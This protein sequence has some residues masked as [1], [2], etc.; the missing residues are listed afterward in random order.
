MEAEAGGLKGCVVYS[1]DLFDAVTIRR[2]M[3]HFDTVLHAVTADDALTLAQLPLLRFAQRHQL[4]HGWNDNRVDLP[5]PRGLHQLFEAQA[6]RT[7]DAGAVVWDEGELSYRCLDRRA[8]HLA[9]WLRARGV[10]PDSRVAICLDPDPALVVGLLA[11]LKAGGGYVPLDP[12]YPSQ[13]LALMLEDSGAQILLTHKRLSPRLPARSLPRLFVDSDGDAAGE[14]RAAPVNGVKESQAA[15][16]LYTSGTTGRPRGVVI[17]HR[18][19]V[20][21]MLWMQATLPLSR[22]DRVLQKTPISFDASVWE[23]WAPLMVGAGLVLARPGGYRDPAYLCRAVRE[24]QVSILQVVPSLLGALLEE[25]EFPRCTSLR[26]LYC[27]GEPL[28]AELCDRFFARGPRTELLNVYGPAEATIHT[29][30]AVVK[31][32]VPV[33][34]GRP[35]ANVRVLLLERSLELVPPGVPGELHIGGANLG[36]G[37]LGQPRATAEKFVPDPFA[38]APGR[39]L[40]RSGDHARFLADGRLKFLGRLDQQIKVRGHRIELG[41]IEAVLGL[42]PQVRRVVVMVRE[43]NPGNRRLVAYVEPEKR[44]GQPDARRRVWEGEHV[45]QWQRFYEDFYSEAAGERTAEERFDTAGWNST[46]TGQPIPAVEMRDWVD[47]TVER[48]LALNPRQVLEIG[49]GTGLV[50]RRVAPRVARYL[51]TDLSHSVL[52]SLRCRLTDLPQVS[53][54]HRRAEDFTG[55]AAGAF[56]TVILN[57]V[58]QY[59][60]SSEFLLTVLRGAV[61]AAAPGGTIFVGDVRSL[62]LLEM[63]C[64][65][66]ELARAEGQV[67]LPKLRERIRRRLLREEELVIAPAFF[68]ALVNELPRVTEVRIRPKD[69]RFQNE[70]TRFR[71]DLVLHLDREPSTPAALPR[72]DWHREGLDLAALRQHLEAHQGRAVGLTGIPNAR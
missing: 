4:L 34:I 14:A 13:R 62:P 9:V 10:G 40:Y 15:Y 24:H 30:F 42:H 44:A 50:L 57:S 61:A 18:A 26:R 16:V 68:V 71:Y 2:W 37:Y 65:S 7:P 22:D 31:P 38:C 11:V 45:A 1:T 48:I 41:E 28:D 32:A 20:N 35:I 46:Y 39:R 27:G 8:N 54:E 55:I 53:L 5:G 70:M 59:F 47:H 43:D 67:T 21:H 33:S 63:F 12:S 17:S 36:R 6:A 29:S 60:P 25:P 58:V 3:E 64:A 72:L 56:D 23:F 51:G 52:E 66:V 69:G 19:I 49:C